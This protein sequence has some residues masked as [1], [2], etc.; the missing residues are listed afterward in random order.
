MKGE[1]VPAAARWGGNPATAVA[2]VN[3]VNDPLPVL[4]I[5]RPGGRHRTED[6]DDQPTPTT[7]PA[8]A[9][10]APTSPPATGADPPAP[11]P[12]TP[13]ARAHRRPGRGN[14]RSRSRLESG[15][16][17]TS[18]AT[19]G[20]M[21]NCSADPPPSPSDTASSRSPKCQPQPELIG[22]K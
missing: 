8:P 5:I 14:S 4:P 15:A 18:S 7:P 10:P 13:P 2:A 11:A 9:S 22:A 16:G 19:H 1:T 6:G 21:Q 12:T 20:G 17:I 3:H